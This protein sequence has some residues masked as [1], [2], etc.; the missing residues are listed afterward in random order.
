MMRA[1]DRDL[2][3]H[4]RHAHAIGHDLKDFGDLDNIAPPNLA[5][6]RPDLDFFWPGAGL[7]PLA[8]LKREHNEYL[9][10]GPGLLGQ[11]CANLGCHYGGTR[12]NSG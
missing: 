12:L 6:L 3:V 8:N 1:L 7:E 2:I 5:E 10:S 9:S 11:A 4:M